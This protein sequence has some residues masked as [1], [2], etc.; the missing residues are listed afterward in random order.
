MFNRKFFPLMFVLF[1]AFMLGFASVYAQDVTPA[2]TDS[3][4]TV[5]VVPPAPTAV[6]TA[7]APT[8]PRGD[9]Q[10]SDFLPYGVL[11][12]GVLILALL[13]LGATGF[14]LLYRS[15]PPAVQAVSLSVVNSLLAQMR[16]YT[17]STPDNLDDLIEAA[18]EKRWQ[19]LQP[20][21]TAPANPVASPN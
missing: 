12:V 14:V 21:L 13:S 9:L 5:V 20:Q 1:I 8:N 11:V 7:I 18:I 3:P 17:T 4:T 16:E 15:A 6:E 10:F 19:A 2:V